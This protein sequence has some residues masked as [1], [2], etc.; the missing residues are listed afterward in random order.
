MRG[1][2]YDHNDPIDIGVDS[3]AFRFPLSRTDS[4]DDH[5]DR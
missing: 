4:G 3:I 5:V 2:C 1:I